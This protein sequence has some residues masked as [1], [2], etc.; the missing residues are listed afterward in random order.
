M[1]AIC[2]DFDYFY[3]M[4]HIADLILWLINQG[5][6]TNGKWLGKRNKLLKEV[7]FLLV[8]LLSKISK[9]MLY[10]FYTHLL[11]L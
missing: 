8:K 7:L 4:R 1:Y 10:L 5:L 3:T 2:L 9:K 11:A 6:L